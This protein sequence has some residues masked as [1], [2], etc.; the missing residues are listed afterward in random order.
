MPYCARLLPLGLGLLLISGTGRAQTPQGSETSSAD[1]TSVQL[2]VYNN[3]LGLVREVRKV[4]LASGTSELRF[5]DVAEKI[6]AETVHIQSRSN[7]AAL[8]VLEQNYEFDLLNPAKLLE[9]YVRRQV[10]LVQ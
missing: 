5:M 7:P 6:M 2:T 3:N 4:R 10:I 8:S 9:K 1:R